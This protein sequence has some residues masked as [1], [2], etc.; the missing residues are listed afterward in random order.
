MID[1]I[2]SSRF[3][4]EEGSNMKKLD[5]YKNMNNSEE[6]HK[7]MKNCEEMCKNV[8]M[9]KS[10][11]FSYELNQEKA[12]TK[13]LKGA[14]KPKHMDIEVKSTCVNMRFDDGSFK[15]VV[16]PLLR[17][18]N[19]KEDSFEFMG[20]TIRVVEAEAGEDN[21]KNHIDT[22]MVIMF[23]THRIVLHCYNGTQN[24]MVQGKQFEK[25]AL[26]C[27]KPYFSQKIEDAGDEIDGFNA[28]VQIALGKPKNKIKNKKEHKKFPCPHCKVKSSTVGDLKMHLK[29]SH[30]LITKKKNISTLNEDLSLLDVSISDQDKSLVELPSKKS[31]INCDWD[32][33]EY[34]S[35]DR[36]LMMKHNCI[37]ILGFYQLR[38][39]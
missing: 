16:L 5:E 21:T 32:P 24:L 28:K 11:I 17:L 10:R 14:M 31:F 7:N 34:K 18:W 38:N 15:E 4:E 35:T 20:A 13:L 36:G 19:K 29:S 25:F 27:L 39:N 30:S 23:D 22:K 3:E 1:S 8:N 37:Q 33:C 26:N 2:V 9:K 6:E 12:K